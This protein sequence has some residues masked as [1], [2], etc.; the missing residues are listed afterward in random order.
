M[1]INYELLRFALMCDILRERE[2]VVV[3]PKSCSSFCFF[4]NH[5]LCASCI[6]KKKGFIAFMIKLAS[7][8]LEVHIALDSACRVCIVSFNQRYTG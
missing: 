6:D 2:T 8:P 5:M 1:M 7:A 3:L 4:F